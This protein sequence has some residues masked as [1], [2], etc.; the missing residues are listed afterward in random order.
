[1]CV[2]GGGHLPGVGGDTWEDV[3]SMFYNL[4]KKTE[5]L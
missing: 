4:T 1:M 2:L 3:L 5:N